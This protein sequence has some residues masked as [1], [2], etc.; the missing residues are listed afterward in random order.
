MKSDRQDG[1]GLDLIK[2]VLKIK[3]QTENASLAS[4]EWSGGETQE[5]RHEAHVLRQGFERL[6]GHR[7]YRPWWPSG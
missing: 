4:R 1:L 3:S 6:P 5:S 7:I 2:V